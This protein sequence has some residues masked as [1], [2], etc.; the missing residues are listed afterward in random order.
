MK[1]TFWAHAYLI[2]SYTFFM[3]LTVIAMIVFSVLI[4]TI[5][6]TSVS[7]FVSL[8]LFLISICALFID[9][10]ALSRVEFSAEGIKYT[11]FKKTPIVC[12]WEDVIEATETLRSW[13]I[14][15]LTFKTKNHQIDLE[16]TKNM[17]ETIMSVCP[18][19]NLKMMINNIDCFK[20][21]NK[22]N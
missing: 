15:W 16:L 19:T 4:F 12:G 17:Y 5:N 22:E 3:I 6:F 10:K 9:N 8:V 13:N 14:S 21:F 20:S 2:S 7:F 11:R 1:K 18:S